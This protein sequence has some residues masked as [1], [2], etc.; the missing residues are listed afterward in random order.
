MWPLK[1][2]VLC[3]PGALPPG[4][5]YV[6]LPRYFVLQEGSCY[7]VRLYDSH[8]KLSTAYS[9]DLKTSVS[10]IKSYLEGSN[11]AAKPMRTHQPLVLS[12]GEDG[13]KSLEICV[14]AAPGQVILPARHRRAA[15]ALRL[16]RW[17]CP[18][19]LQEVPG[20]INPEVRVEQ[21]LGK[22]MH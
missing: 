11:S 18:A 22:V 20:P 17:A 8:C 6:V 15:S 5:S 16:V 9:D 12:V 7:Q 4:N 1:E 3:K 13:S 2:G 21:Q 10:R 14:E 19:A